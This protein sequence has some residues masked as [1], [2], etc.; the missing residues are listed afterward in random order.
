MAK[1]KPKPARGLNATSWLTTQWP[2]G[3]QSCALKRGLSTRRLQ[4]FVVACGD[5]M[6]SAMQPQP[7]KQ[8]KALARTAEGT[9]TARDREGL[10]ECGPFPKW[11]GWCLGVGR[12]VEGLR[13]AAADLAREVFGNPFRPV[14][15]SPDWRTSTA[16]ALA[17][18]MYKTREFG[19]MPILADA[20][21]DAGCDNDDV[22][23]HCRQ[24]GTHV[25]GCWVVDLVLGKS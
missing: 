19:A 15:F 14:E 25:R 4:L 24:P 7:R 16:V 1:Q 10:K 3:M 17:A 8:F 22:L 18:Q 13:P 2:L 11:L 6:W 9:D 21:Q 12:H 5:L 20:L 23:N